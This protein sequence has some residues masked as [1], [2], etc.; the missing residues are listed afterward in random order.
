MLPGPLPPRPTAHPRSRFRAGPP[1]YRP[2]EAGNGTAGTPRRPPPRAGADAFKGGWFKRSVTVPPRLVFA[3]CGA[4]RATGRI[5]NTALGDSEAGRGGGGRSAPLGGRWGLSPAHG[6]TPPG[7]AGRREEILSRDAVGA[8]PRAEPGTE[9]GDVSWRRNSPRSAGS[10]VCAPIP[11]KH[12]TSAF[13]LS[14]RS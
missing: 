1:R 7:T 11:G 10:A 12:R 5:T 4:A 6:R 2:A 9:P 3:R 14:P 8:E 13:N